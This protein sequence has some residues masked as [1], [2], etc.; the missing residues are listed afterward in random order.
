MVQ[1]AKCSAFMPP[2]A[3]QKGEFGEEAGTAIPPMVS[4]LASLPTLHSHEDIAY[5]KKKQE[6][7]LGGHIRDFHQWQCIMYR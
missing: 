5:R 4:W 6:N 1:S 3:K 7:I 2:F